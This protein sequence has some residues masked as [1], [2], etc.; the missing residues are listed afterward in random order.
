[1]IP[2]EIPREWEDTSKGRYVRHIFG[3][4]GQAMGV[5][6][7]I[8]APHAEPETYKMLVE[9]DDDDMAKLTLTRKVWVT[10]YGSHLHPWRVDVFEV[11]M[12]A[13]GNGHGQH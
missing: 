7:L 1:M 5:D 9:L 2:V 12:G 8:E 4:P 6:A 3:V 11:T 13:D 10:F